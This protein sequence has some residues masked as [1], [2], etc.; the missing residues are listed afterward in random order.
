M[1]D[2][3]KPAPDAYPLVGASEAAD[4]MGVELSTFSHLRRR[5]GS[6]ENSKFPKPVAVLRCGPIWKTSEI[7]RFAKKYEKPRPGPRPT[8]TP[9]KLPTAVVEPPTKPPTK[10]EVAGNGEK[11]TRKK[12]VAKAPAKTA[13][14]KKAAP[15]RKRAARKAV[16][17]VV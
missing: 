6:V 14:A 7:M 5:E 4:L 1:T 9:R 11:Q 10:A 13:V 15:R 3:T 17:A 12:A 16:P 8:A 2:P